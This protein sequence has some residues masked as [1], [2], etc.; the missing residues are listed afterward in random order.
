MVSM[1]N[2]KSLAAQTA[3]VRLRAMVLTNELTV[4]NIEGKENCCNVYYQGRRTVYVHTFNLDFKHTAADLARW[5]GQAE[6]IDQMI[7]SSIHPAMVVNRGWS[8]VSQQKL[9]C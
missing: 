4:E 3:E 7:E 1:S 2:S 6:I 5:L 9:P 8:I